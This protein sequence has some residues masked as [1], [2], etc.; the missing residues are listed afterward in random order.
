MAWH[1]RFAFLLLVAFGIP[2][3][4]GA[5]WNQFRGPDGLGTS[6]E[7]NLPS[8]WSSKK[9][10]VWKTR[11]PGPGTSSPVTTGSRVFL[12][13]YTGY[14]VA[15]D[16]PGK[17][18]DLR[19]Q[20]LCLDRK[21]G[22]ILWT[23]EFEPILPEHKYA[24]EGAYHGYS[25]STPITD[26]KRLYV[27]FGKSGVFCFDLE[28]KQLWHTLVGKNVHGWGSGTS[29]VLYKNLL[30][31]NASVESGALVALDKMSGKEIWRSAG[32]SSSWNTPVLVP[33]SKGVFE[34]VVSVQDRLLGFD[35]ETGKE[36]WQ[37][38]GIHR[39]VCPSV[40]AHEGVVYAIGGGHT[41]L[42]VRAGGR[43]NVTKTHTVWRESKGSNVSSPVY[44]DGHL[45]WAGDNGLVYCQEAATGKTVYQKR[46]A[47][48]AGLI[49]ASPLLA[50]GKI[51]YVSQ[52]KGT[53]V[54]AA[55]PKFEL[56]EHNVFA[57]DNSRT[58]GS[59]AVS[60]GQLLLRSDQDLY[61]IGT[62]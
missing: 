9:N 52:R 25:S 49:Y 24:G 32:I 60:E 16:D 42:A 41:S 48:A 33:L 61:C 59:P 31:V 35:P 28:G 37:A 38:E 5:D 10:I 1:H 36:L 15:T 39:Y 13:S 2:F 34:V 43:G 29:P 40:V 17:M 19:R 11:L 45:Y 55:S 27:F 50:G 26:G 20:V 47:P 3:T 6:T 7:K 53:Y 8:Q 21:N 4:F 30:I 46:L 56:L 22:K 58:N 62:R 51:Y 57:D 54:V 44:H 23:K 12:T 18:E 14:A